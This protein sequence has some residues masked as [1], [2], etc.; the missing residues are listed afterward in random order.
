[1]H[2]AAGRLSAAG[3]QDATSLQAEGARPYKTPLSTKLVTSSK[4]SRL[5]AYRA[6]SNSNI[7]HQPTQL[8][9]YGMS[10]SC[11]CSCE[12]SGDKT[13]NLLITVLCIACFCTQHSASAAL[14]SGAGILCTS[15][16][17]SAMRA[18]AACRKLILKQAPV[19][20]A[21][22]DLELPNLEGIKLLLLR[23]PAFGAALRS[24]EWD[25]QG[26]ISKTT[27]T[28][29][30][31]ALDASQQLSGG[32]TASAGAVTGAV[33]ATATPPQQLHPAQEGHQNTLADPCMGCAEVP[34]A[35]Q[36]PPAAAAV[37]RAPCTAGVAA[38]GPAQDTA[39]TQAAHAAG[40][41]TASATATGR[42]MGHAAGTSAATETLP[43][44]DSSPAAVA[45]STSS[46]GSSRRQSLRPT[47]SIDISSLHVSDSSGDSSSNE[48]GGNSDE[49]QPA[50][51]HDPAAAAPG[52]AAAAST[53]KD[54]PQ[55][56]TVSA[57]RASVEQLCPA[58]PEP[59][60]A[61][62]AAG[63]AGTSR[64]R[65]HCSTPGHVLHQP[66]HVYSNPLTASSSDEDGPDG[67]GAA[68]CRPDACSCS[69]DLQ[70]ADS[71]TQT[72]Q[73]DDM[74]RPPGSSARCSTSHPSGAGKAGRPAEPPGR[75]W[76]HKLSKRPPTP[77]VTLSQPVSGSGSSVETG[78]ARHS[79]VAQDLDDSQHLVS[80]A[81]HPATGSSSSSSSHAGL[82]SAIKG[83]QGT[84]SSSGGS[85]HPAR[86]HSAPG[87][88]SSQPRQSRQHWH[89][90]LSAR[91][92]TP[93]ISLGKPVSIFS[94]DSGTADTEVDN[95]AGGHQHLVTFTANT[96]NQGRSG[97]PSCS[98]AA[99]RPA[100]D[101][102]QPV[103]QQHASHH[104]WH[105]KL[106]KR[107][108][109][110]G[111]GLGQPVSIF[112]GS[113]STA[114]VH[115]DNE[116]TVNNGVAASTN[117]TTASPPGSS[118]RS[119]HEVEGGLVATEDQQHQQ[120][121]HHKLSKRPATPGVSLGKPVSIFSASGTSSPEQEP[122]TGLSG[123]PAW[124]SEQNKEGHVHFEP[125][126]S[127]T[128]SKHTHTRPQSAP[129]RHYW[130]TAHEQHGPSW[131]PSQ[132]H[133]HSTDRAHE[134]MA[135]ALTRDGSAVAQHEANAERA[136]AGC[137]G[138]AQIGSRSCLVS[139]RNSQ[140]DVRGASSDDGEGAVYSSSSR[141]DRKQVSGTRQQQQQQQRPAQEQGKQWHQK[142]S[143]RPPTPGLTLGQPISIFSCSTDACAANHA[144]AETE[145]QGHHWQACPHQQ[146][147]HASI[148]AE[149][150]ASRVQHA[151]A[152]S[153][154]DHP[155][156]HRVS[157]SDGPELAMQLQDGGSEQQYD[158]ER[159]KWTGHSA[160]IS[161]AQTFVSPGCSATGGSSG[162]RAPEPHSRR[163]T[164]A[165]EAAHAASEVSLDGTAAV[166]HHH[167][168]ADVGSSSSSSGRHKSVQFRHTGSESEEN[169][170]EGEGNVSPGQARHSIS[171][172]QQIQGPETKQ[173]QHGGVHFVLPPDVAAQPPSKAASCSSAPGSCFRN[174]DVA[175][176]LQQQHWKDKL[177]HRPPTPD[178]TLGKQLDSM[179]VDSPQELPA[180]AGAQ[181]KM[182]PAAAEPK[183][184]VA[185]PGAA[186]ALGGD[187]RG[188]PGDR[189][190]SGLLV[191]RNPDLAAD[192]QQQKWQ[193]HLLK[194]PPTPGAPLPLHNNT[195][196]DMDSA[197]GEEEDSPTD[198]ASTG[199][200][201]V[202]AAAV[203][204]TAARTGPGSRDA[205]TAVARQ[206]LLRQ[207]PELAAEA[208][209]QQWQQHMSR[210]PPT[211]GASLHPQANIFAGDDKD[212]DEEEEDAP[213][214]EA[215]AAEGCARDDPTAATH[216]A[217][218]LEGA[219]PVG[220][221]PTA[222]NS[223]VDTA[224]VGAAGDS[225]ASP[226]A[227]SSSPQR[228]S[229]AVQALLLRH[230]PELAA[231]Q[232]LQASG[233]HS[234]R[235]PTPS[236]TNP[237]SIFKQATSP[238][239]CTQDYSA[240]APA[241]A[242]S[243][244]AS[245]SSSQQ[246]SQAISG[247]H[248]VEGSAAGVVV[249]LKPHLALEKQQQWE[250]SMSKRPPTPAA[251]LGK[252]FNMFAD[253]EQ[254][255]NAVLGRAG[256]SD[257]SC[258]STM[259][260]VAPAAP[261]A[262]SA[263]A[264]R[265]R[266]LSP[267]QVRSA[268]SSSSGGGSGVNTSPSAAVPSATAPPSVDPKAR[269]GSSNP[270]RQRGSSPLRNMTTPAAA[271]ASDSEPV[272]RSPLRHSTS[273]CDPDPAR[274]S[275]LGRR[276][277]YTGT[278]AP[279]SPVA[280]AAAAPVEAVGQCSTAVSQDVSPGRQ[281]HGAGE[282]HSPSRLCCTAVKEAGR[283]S[284]LSRSSSRSPSPNPSQAVRQGSPLSRCSSGGLC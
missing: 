116:G 187:D 264:S 28:R 213:Q 88:Q 82:G 186:E 142:L 90:R 95:T 270:G 179:F 204:S 231:E 19:L 128:G 98:R 140:P 20:P 274:M 16:L 31:T 110:P 202:S 56:D 114:P 279:S 45:G 76:Q 8:A 96:S 250:L 23:Y 282:P 61:A 36:T 103:S 159:E 12:P 108:P 24:L 278:S 91:P 211:P 245:S 172:Q 10:N 191:H 224:A 217:V 120:H 175:A 212:D 163:L 239:I 254:D 115:G 18:A 68:A 188:S 283:S 21:P 210:R 265:S 160:A 131:Q 87:L 74:R 147:C 49:D 230:R 199:P 1:M 269:P 271:P 37:S 182:V 205:S 145:P 70:D 252:P 41:T 80:F 198:G 107:P 220:C 124:S 235:P 197:T 151:E 173:Q 229:V 25:E 57:S 180:A 43:A 66:M 258:V 154:Q 227:G 272:T 69:N 113:G 223:A 7:S 54:H 169:D 226:G 284:P 13:L 11:K 244:G 39:C 89:D 193:G 33:A 155:S 207:R 253:D 238:L 251:T 34:N 259:R 181:D 149:E 125:A 216:S 130:G 215:E 143:H 170:D 100:A 189:S 200:D 233:N 22:A 73:E 137:V 94:T 248:G 257:G 84:T 225:A 275:P 9:S 168:A 164:W 165:D 92:P 152:T 47:L 161:K 85:H 221:S 273:M 194:R 106:S 260:A 104:E 158:S 72:Q 134:G 105:Q 185:A 281:L 44:G 201:S 117:G 174:P 46:A 4:P 266:S 262:A 184:A 122:S 176:E 65:K 234:K 247:S 62:A 228:P 157:W 138:D 59:T 75:S 148:N 236:V 27:L 83:T 14:N 241:A 81:L 86:P 40:S 237:T 32:Q 206:A 118:S 196:A 127:H 99:A 222:G 141:S 3:P 214:L 77:G 132:A 162:S 42:N 51:S 178:V 53:S 150:C 52:G 256:S 126:S 263:T 219:V 208:Q 203:A 109:T 55:H 5:P 133:N 171:C 166:P 268:R 102:Q 246:P 38:P 111:A 2:P 261:A 67:A 144:A 240:G 255:S 64:P 267:D 17:R 29:I 232:E 71:S 30:M 135:H 78:L 136:G 129:G 63:V 123:G 156:A 167:S 242:A 277:S 121:W 139:F 112:S 101:M 48:D 249:P 6:G 280:L 177:S 183:A 192:A 26:R 119:Y 93:G 195:F 190:R 58:L 218:R 79:T 146:G 153:N 60:G 35:A 243:S 97:A 50:G 15:R 276:S 209:Q